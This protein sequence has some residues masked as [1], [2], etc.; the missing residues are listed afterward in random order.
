MSL[1]SQLRE[2]IA[3]QFVGS[4]LL[5]RD[6]DDQPEIVEPGLIYLIGNYPK[7]W[8]ATLLCPCSCGSV[9]QL[10]LLRD[11]DPRWKAVRHFDGTISLYPSVWRT[12]GCK[13]HFF[14]RHG[15]IV[16]AKNLPVSRGGARSRLDL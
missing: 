10:S 4:R 12:K 14:V 1:S 11:D 6:V 15:R 3:R 7:P 16:W 5:A 8:S 2:W 13:S 9:I